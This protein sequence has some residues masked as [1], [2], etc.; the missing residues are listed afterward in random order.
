MAV[1]ASNKKNATRRDVSKE[2]PPGNK[3]DKMIIDRVDILH[4]QIPLSLPYETS[5]Q[6]NICL[7]KIILKVFTKDAV[8]FSECVCKDIPLSTYET[9]GT[10]RTILKN[11]ILPA[12]LGK[13]IDEPKD[14]WRLAGH[15]KG[16]NMAKAGVENAAWALF[17]LEK[18][19][20]IATLLGGEK[21]TVPVGH[22]IGIQTSVE[23]LLDL[24]AQYLDIGF[25]RIK[26]KI[27]HGWDIAVL[28]KVRAQ[29]PDLTLMV[30]ANT[31]Y[32]W[33]ADK[34]ILQ[35]LDQFNLTM[36]EQ[37]LVWEDLYFHAA[38]Q[39]CIE[40]PICLDES[41][42]SPYTANAAGLMKSCRIINIK[43]GR[44]GGLLPSLAIHDISREH[45][46]GC[47]VGQMI[48][49]GLAL[50]YGLAVG[51]LGNCI[52]H[53]DLIPTRYYLTDDIIVPEM[54]LN[55]DSTVN[56]PEQ[57]GIGVMVDEMKLEHYT[58][59]KDVVKTEQPSSI[60]RGGSTIPEGGTDN[61]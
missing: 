27:S 29:Y 58:V 16:H 7:D 61:K 3:D 50:T 13:K 36:I 22:G 42:I 4:V 60:K 46:I 12:V 26:L 14:F 34:H 9:P 53:N 48:E 18:G 33:P 44:V 32:Q 24:I 35:A 20:P 52:Y 59:N 43:Q 57:P 38:L 11:F 40:T 30:D 49:T 5:Y 56:V 6:K 47:W 55:P 37:P 10:V 15:F 25:N 28:E 21:T 31:D 51:S 39:A 1:T 54:V 8:V 17:S 45:K 23:K 2:H 19:L 41:I